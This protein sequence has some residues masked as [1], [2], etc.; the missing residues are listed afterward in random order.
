MYLGQVLTNDGQAADL[1]TLE[2]I[3]HIIEEI[4]KSMMP[5]G[6]VVIWNQDTDLQSK[7]FE[8]NGFEV[9]LDSGGIFVLRK[10]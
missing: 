2:K 6:V 4:N 9:L 3:Q 8:E 7:D 10:I 5:D 1:S